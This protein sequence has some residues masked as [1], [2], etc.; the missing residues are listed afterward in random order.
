MTSCTAIFDKHDSK[1][2]IPF[3]HF[4][5]DGATKEYFEHVEA[6]AKKYAAA[7]E[8]EKKFS[9]SVPNTARNPLQKAVH[10]IA[11]S[12]D[13]EDVNSLRK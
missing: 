12:V 10:W 6:F 4:W 1:S 5:Q 3:L 2:G 7:G 8:Q 11:N 13:R 9:V